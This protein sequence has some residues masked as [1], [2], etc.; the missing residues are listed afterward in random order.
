MVPSNMHV[1]VTL[2]AVAGCAVANANSIHN[3]HCINT[4]S[5]MFV[6]RLFWLHL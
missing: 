1:N 6:R 4:G 2:T 5:S 3:S